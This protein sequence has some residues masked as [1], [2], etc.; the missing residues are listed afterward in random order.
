MNEVVKFHNDLN[1]VAMRRW[2]KEEMNFFFSIIAKAREQ[3]SK[4]LV[5]QSQELKELTKFAGDYNDRWNDIMDKVTNK[6]A[7]LIYTERTTKKKVVMTLF[8][9][10]EV[11]FEEQTVTVQVSENFQYILNQIQANFTSFELEEFTEIRST[12]AKTMYRLLKQWRIQGRKV[13]SVQEFRDY[14]DIPKSFK[15]GMVAKRV[16]D[17]IKKELSPYFKNLNITPL[18]SKSQGNPITGYEFTWQAELTGEWKDFNDL[19]LKKKQKGQPKTI[20]SE[21]VPENILTA[22]KEEVGTKK[23]IQEDYFQKAMLLRDKSFEEQAEFFS[24]A[25]KVDT[26]RMPN[27]TQFLDTLS[28][29]MAFDSEKYWAQSLSK[30]QTAGEEID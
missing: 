27:A 8:S 16:L 26:Y 18:K 4:K 7:Q 2:S 28:T 23:K 13:Y 14:L 24:E 6:V 30:N 20:R 17:P 19:N 12:Y 3:E 21:T 5:F 10:F 1:T 15:A 25:R 29:L 22:E 9:R 11:D